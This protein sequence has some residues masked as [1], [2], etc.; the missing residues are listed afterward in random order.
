MLYSQNFPGEM[1]LDLNIFDNNL[2]THEKLSK[3]LGRVPRWSLSDISPSN[4]FS[5]KR[6]FCKR[7][8]YINQV[9]NPYAAGGSFCQYKI[10]QKSWKMIEIL[11]LGYSSERTQWEL[12]NEYQRDRDSMVFKHLCILLL[13]MNV[14]LALEGLRLLPVWKCN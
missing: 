10:M 13:W 7:Y 3:Y 4:I 1:F 2:I 11:A 9:F 14:A 6:L 12:S 5:Q 8:H